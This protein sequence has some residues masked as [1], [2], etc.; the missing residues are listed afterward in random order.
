MTD[1][2]THVVTGANGY[3]GRYLTRRL[4]A[5]GIEVRSLTGH[6]DRPD[7]FDGHVTNHG[8][9][10]DDPDLLVRTLTGARVLYNS[11]WVR[12]DHGRTTFEQAV[13]NTRI[14]FECAK[15]A[16]VERVVHVSITNPSLKSKLPYF[17][18]KAALEQSLRDSGLSHAIVRPT[19]LFGKEDIL[20]NNIAN[21]L[22]RL[23]VLGVPGRGDYGIQPVYVDDLAEL[24]VE[25]GRATEN[26]TIDA[27]GPETMS[28]VDMVRFVR[29]TVGA[30][31]RVIGVPGW[32]VLAIGKLLG[33]VVGDVVITADEIR[34]LSA[35]LLV[36][37]DPPTCTTSFSDWVSNHRD[38]LGTRWASELSR[39]YR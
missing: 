19:V 28:Y 27:V 35:G 23:P 2:E 17:R 31:A 39:H 24:M 25:Q 6:P 15:R 11:Y 8:F 20:I 36:S 37:D 21:L 18:G 30:R 13:A 16:G 29:D 38:T 1:R 34:G 3:T 26:V 9:D 4:L 10:F 14:L 5:E 12:F 32:M 7:L 22:R 33:K